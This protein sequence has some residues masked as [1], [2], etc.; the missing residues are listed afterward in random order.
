MKKFIQIISGF[1][2]LSIFTSYTYSQNLP[3]WQR[4]YRDLNVSPPKSEGY[5]MCQINDER[6]LKVACKYSKRV[7]NS[8]FINLILLNNF[9]KNGV[10][11]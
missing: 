9:F 5:D 1:I 11:L 3:T 10:R 7:P 6:F 4:E 8:S 2:I